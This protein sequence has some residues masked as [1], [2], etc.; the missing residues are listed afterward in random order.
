[1]KQ[2]KRIKLKP[3]SLRT[4]NDAKTRKLVAE[5]VAAIVARKPVERNAWLYTIALHD[6]FGF[7][8]KMIEKFA[9]YYI[10][11]AQEYEEITRED[12]QEVADEKLRRR[13]EAITGAEITELYGGERRC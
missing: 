4:W 5:E 1:M 2:Y 13:A 12:G 6:A 11:V 8:A 10:E 3:S 7:G 9:R